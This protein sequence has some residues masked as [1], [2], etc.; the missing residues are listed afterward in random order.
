MASTKLSTVIAC[1]NREAFAQGS[2]SDEAI[3]TSSFRGDAK[4][5]NPESRDS[6]MCSAH[7][8]SGAGAPSRNDSFPDCFAEPV[9]GPAEGGTRWLLAMMTTTTSVIPGRA[10]RE[11]GISRRNVEVPDRSAPQ[12]VRN[13]NRVKR[14]I[15]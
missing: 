11:P 13:D 4:A 10:Q 15:P 6:L 1:D 9:I 8:R 14:R 7:L 3:Q 12:T 2:A 5:S